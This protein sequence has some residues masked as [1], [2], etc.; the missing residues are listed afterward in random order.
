MPKFYVSVPEPGLHKRL[1]F[2]LSLLPG[3]LL[4]LATLPLPSM[5]SWQLGLRF[6]V[7]QEYRTRQAEAGSLGGRICFHTPPEIHRDMTVACL[8]YV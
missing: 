5:L 6:H 7:L 2:S 1:I 8:A 4:T 3:S